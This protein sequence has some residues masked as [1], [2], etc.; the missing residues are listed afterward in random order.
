MYFN[1]VTLD[2]SKA[3]VKSSNSGGCW[4][5]VNLQNAVGG[6]Y[7]MVCGCRGMVEVSLFQIIVTIFYLSTNFLCYYIYLQN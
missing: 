2:D 1:K 3:I 6:H 4:T 5:N 7:M